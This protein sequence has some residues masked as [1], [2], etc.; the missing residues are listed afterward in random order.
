VALGLNPVSDVL[1]KAD[2]VLASAGDTL[3]TVDTK[4]AEVHKAVTQT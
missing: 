1:K 2:R 4:L 3:G